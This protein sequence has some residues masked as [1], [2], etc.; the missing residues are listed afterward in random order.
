MHCAHVK[1]PDGFGAIVCRSGP[2]HPKYCTACDQPAPFLCD[3]KVGGGKTCDLPIC[4]VHAEEVAEDK[5]LC[6]KHSK[7][8]AQWQAQRGRGNRE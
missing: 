1:L 2:R 7:A 8:W 4:P 5:H 3:W 6:P